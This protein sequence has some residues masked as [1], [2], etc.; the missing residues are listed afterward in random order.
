MTTNKD[1]I[2][3]I[4]DDAGMNAASIALYMQRLDELQ[5]IIVSE[6]RHS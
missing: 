4:L 5:T 2:I 6:S 3:L 1:K